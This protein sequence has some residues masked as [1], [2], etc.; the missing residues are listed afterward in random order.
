MK[1]I[2]AAGILFGAV[3][4]PA[5]AGPYVEVENN[6][7]WI[8]T[9]FENAVT[10]VHAG[11]EVKPAANVTLFVQ[12]GPAFVAVKDEDTVTEYSGKAG[13]KAHLSR[14]LEVYGEFAFITEDQEI[15]TDDFVFGT[16]LG[17]TYK[18]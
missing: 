10:E 1:S 7:D 11:V 8:G 12:G 2:I 6:A 9:D 4:A 13:L 5:F 14:K 15:D 18:F 17:A 16:K 3:S